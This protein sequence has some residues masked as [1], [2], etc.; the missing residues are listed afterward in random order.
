MEW[1]GVSGVIGLK[2]EGPILQ[3]LCLALFDIKKKTAPFKKQGNGGQF[4]WCPPLGAPTLSQSII[5]NYTCFW[6]HWPNVNI[7][8]PTIPPCLNILSL[9]FWKCPTPLQYLLG[10]C[11]RSIQSWNCNPVQRHIPI[12]LLLESN[13]SHS[14]EESVGGPQ[15]CSITIM[16]EYGFLAGFVGSFHNNSNRE[17]SKII[18]WFILSNWLVSKKIILHLTIFCF[19]LAWYWNLKIFLKR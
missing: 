16:P 3:P 1:V 8:V 18:C 9:E 17:K 15:C 11:T 7:A 5:F 10:K 13:I 14:Q 2:T 12:S 4:L 6:S 19:S